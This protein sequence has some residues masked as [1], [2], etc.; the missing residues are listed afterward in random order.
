VFA[1]ADCS[2]GSRTALC[3]AAAAAAAACDRVGSLD[4]NSIIISPFK[5]WAF[6]CVIMF[7]SGT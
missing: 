1:G 7:N 5:S 4:S 6:L 3:L 2:V